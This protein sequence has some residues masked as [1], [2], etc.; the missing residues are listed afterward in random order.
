[1]ELYYIYYYIKLLYLVIWL[2]SLPIFLYM[3]PME[4]NNLLFLSTAWRWV[5]ILSRLPRVF[6]AALRR[7]AAYAILRHRV[8]IEYYLALDTPRLCCAA[9][10]LV[11]N[12]DNSNLS[13]L[14]VYF[15]KIAI[16]YENSYFSTM[17]CNKFEYTMSNQQ[18]NY[19]K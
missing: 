14:Q 15:K 10:T 2:I 11:M 3:Y 7:F 19:I 9:S 8:G 1:M 4:I 16:H 5:I 6:A 12:N 18:I 13:K 17:Y